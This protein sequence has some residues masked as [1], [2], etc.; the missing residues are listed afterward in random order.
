MS[1]EQLK[2]FWEVIQSD[3]ELQHKLSGVTDL[4]AIVEIAKG[5]GFT[6]STEE[7]QNAQSEPQ[8]MSWKARLAAFRF[9]SLTDSVL[10]ELGYI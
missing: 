8:I 9:F 4:D 1:E 6:F 7:L 10:R 3:P 5:A 2:A